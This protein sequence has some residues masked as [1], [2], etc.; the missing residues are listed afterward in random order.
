MEVKTNKEYQA[1]QKEITTAEEAVR[2]HE[3][4]ILDRME[5][6]DTLA[7]GP[8]R[9]R[10]RAQTQQA[11]I[12]RE[13]QALDEE[14]VALAMQADQA[15]GRSTSGS[16]E[17]CRRQALRCS[18]TSRASAKGSPSPKRATDSALVCHVRLRPQVYNEVRRNE[19]LIQCDSCSRILY[20]VPEPLAKA[21]PRPRS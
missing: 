21:P 9:G 18:S 10:E 6:A 19:S 8:E 12:A 15:T 20:F 2:A 5:E 14:A 3:D 17:S 11:E 7:R 1:M 4:R 13:R 16:R